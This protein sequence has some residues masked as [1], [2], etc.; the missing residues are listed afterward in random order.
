MPRI[1]EKTDESEKNELYKAAL[2]E[3]FKKWNCFHRDLEKRTLCRKTLLH[4]IK[5]NIVFPIYLKSIPNA[6][7]EQMEEMWNFSA[8]DSVSPQSTSSSPHPDIYLICPRDICRSTDIVTEG[9]DNSTAICK[10]CGHTWQIMGGAKEMFVS[11]SQKNM[12]TIQAYVDSKGNEIDPKFPKIFS[13]S[14]TKEKYYKNSIKELVELLTKYNKQWSIA[15]Y[16]RLVVQVAILLSVY[17]SSL[18]ANKGMP[19]KEKRLGLMALLTYYGSLLTNRG[20][21]WE[22]ILKIFGVLYEDVEKVKNKEMEVFWTTKEGNKIAGQ[23]FPLILKENA[24]QKKDT[25]ETQETQETDDDSIEYLTYKKLNKANKKITLVG[26]K[27]FI[28]SLKGKTLKSMEKV[29]NAKKGEINKQ[30]KVV[31]K[32]FDEHQRDLADLRD[33]I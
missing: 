16:D 17:L 8:K 2:N 20:L 13:D 14:T 3:R 19:K 27:A 7:R 25:E 11:R 6:T 33:L 32:W 1:K 12:P 15:V 21:S 28:M 26:V 18:P 30:K 31:E 29:L 23:L 10:S 24:R 9:A 22:Q 4:L 5:I